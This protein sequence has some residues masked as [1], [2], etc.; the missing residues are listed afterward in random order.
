MP[1][2]KL[3]H[4]V[5]ELEIP[6]TKEKVKYRPFLVKEEKILLLAQSSGLAGDVVT[7]I[8]QIINNCT[9][10]GD[11]NVDTLPSF[12]LEF[13]FLRL[14]AHSVNDMAKLKFNDPDND[15]EIEV[16][17]DLKEIQVH[18]SEEHTNAINLSGDISLLMRYPTY[19]DYASISYDPTEGNTAEAITSL[20]NICVDKV[21]AGEDVHEFK[22]YSPEEVNEFVDSFSGQNFKD[23]RKFF[24][25]SP[26]LEHT[27][28]YKVGN[29]KKQYTFKGISDFLS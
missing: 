9:V 5:F 7:A 2:P 25:T 17:V 21:Y 26:R 4:P 27:I 18:F 15:K 6:S 16:E 8:K 23:I 10:E 14:R 22:D 29:K 13:F 3:E 28:D 20:I 12:D 19:D 11:I 24:D 1:L